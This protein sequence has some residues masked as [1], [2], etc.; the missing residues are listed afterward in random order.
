M[1]AQIAQITGIQ[2][3]IRCAAR[4]LLRG[5]LVCTWKSHEWNRAPP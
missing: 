4:Y 5:G 1:T 2:A 3:A